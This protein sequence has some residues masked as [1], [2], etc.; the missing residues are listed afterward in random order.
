MTIVKVKKL[1]YK[2][3]AFCVYFIKNG[4]NGTQ[5]A[6]SAGYSKNCLTEIAAQN[7]AK[8][9]IKNE[10]ERLKGNLEEVLQISKGKILDE[11]KKIAFSSMEELHDTWITRKKF[12]SLSPDQMACIQSIETNEK[13]RMIR[14]RLYDKQKALDSISKLMG[15]DAPSKIE[16]EG[17]LLTHKIEVGVVNI[18]LPLLHSES[19]IQDKKL[20]N[21]ETM[22]PCLGEGLQNP[23]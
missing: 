14:I 22:Q 3:K 4:Y 13:R 16:I 7:L 9:H 20:I 18:A 8:L 21:G 2:E 11:H 5:A 10:I 12:D 15:Y 19:E 17:N 1:T 6:K 23:D